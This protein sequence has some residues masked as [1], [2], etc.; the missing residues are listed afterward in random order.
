[1]KA[2]Y[3]GNFLSL[4]EGLTIGMAVLYNLLILIFMHIGQADDIFVLNVLIMAAIFLVAYL[5]RRFQHPWLQVFRDWAVV[6]FLIIIYMENRTLIPLTNPR[7][8]DS[9]VMAADRFLF[10]GHDPTVLMEKIMYPALSEV[11]QISYASFYFLPL[12]LCAILYFSRE[13]RDDFHI[14][15]STIFMG[16]YL[17]YIGY[18]FT[19]VLGPR[20]TME[21]LQSIP[22][23]GLWTFDFL[24][25]LLAQAEGRMYDCMPS[26][27]AL[28]SMLTV[29]LSWRYAKRFFPVALV[30]TVLLSFSTVYLRYHYVTDLVAGMALGVLVYRFGPDLAM[31]AMLGREKEQE[32][33]ESMQLGKD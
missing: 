11:L 6:S 23:R 16:F 15:A 24:R 13:N 9:M 7:D 28:V 8:L 31:A 21:H 12:G 10:L 22:L 26:G 18:Y 4:E 25:N 2:C 17:S 1:M 33:S 30:W 14:A 3:P 27:H 29:L 32:K 5:H 19:P 20:F